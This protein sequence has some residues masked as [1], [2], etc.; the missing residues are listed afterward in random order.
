MRRNRLAGLFSLLAL[1]ACEAP[2]AVYVDADAATYR[3]LAPYA[4]AGIEA[5]ATLDEDQREDRLSTIAT[6]E[7]RI[8]LNGGK[9]E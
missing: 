9:T 7:M 3:I 2:H 8:R 4:R 6:W 5:D 1:A